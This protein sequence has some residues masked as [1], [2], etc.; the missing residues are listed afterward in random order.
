M[1]AFWHETSRGNIYTPSNS[2]D[3]EKLPI[4]S[5]LEIISNVNIETMLSLRILCKKLNT[6]VSRVTSLSLKQTSSYLTHFKDFKAKYNVLTKIMP[7]LKS[8]KIH[9]IIDLRETLR[10]YKGKIINGHVRNKGE[11]KKDVLCFREYYLNVFS[12]LNDIK[13]K[14]DCSMESRNSHNLMAGHD[15]AAIMNYLLFE[16]RGN[17]RINKYRQDV[18]DYEALSHPSDSLNF[19]GP[20]PTKSSPC[21]IIEFKTCFKMKDGILTIAHGMQKYS[22]EVI[23]FNA[24]RSGVRCSDFK[25]WDEVKGI[26]IKHPHRMTTCYNTVR[27]SPCKTEVSSRCPCKCGRWNV[28][29]VHVDYKRLHDKIK[30][31][32]I[33][34]N[35]GCV[36]D[37]HED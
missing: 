12:W 33:T 34:F 16:A 9:L 6:N 19:V 36:M 26:K 4:D 10:G 29:K 30:D 28:N 2:L 20:E 14:V 21:P 37:R 32:P 11:T 8:M 25:I 7:N 17:F 24:T 3:M 5:F 15:A 13:A 27:G 18:K 1:I 35:K 23:Y 22:H 31:V